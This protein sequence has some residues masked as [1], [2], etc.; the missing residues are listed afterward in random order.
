MI[1]KPAL[2]AALPLCPSDYFRH[3]AA[4]LP[5][6]CWVFVA[7]GAHPHHGSFDS[8]NYLASLQRRGSSEYLEGAQLNMSIMPSLFALFL[9]LL[10]ESS[11]KSFFFKLLQLRKPFLQGF[12]IRH[13]YECRY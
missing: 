11:Q 1:V 3:Q 10:V 2:G 6:A 13:T 12:A 5:S 7:G 9:H 4:A 8:H